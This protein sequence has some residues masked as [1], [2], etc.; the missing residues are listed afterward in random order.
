MAAR[1]LVVKVVD[2]QDTG[3]GLLAVN[4]ECACFDDG[5]MVG[6]ETGQLKITGAETA[7]QFKTKWTDA[8]L[9]VGTAHGLTIARN[10]AIIPSWD[11]GA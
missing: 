11:R 5:V 9:A 10:Q 8:V 7:N 2:V 4:F 6:V 1:G 3:E